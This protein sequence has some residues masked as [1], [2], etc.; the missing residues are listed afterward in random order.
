MYVF[1]KEKQTGVVSHFEEYCLKNAPQVTKKI[2]KTYYTQGNKNPVS[3][4]L[5]SEQTCPVQERVIFSFSG[6]GGG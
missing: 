5:R 1:V 4:Y 3:F 2:N 6:G